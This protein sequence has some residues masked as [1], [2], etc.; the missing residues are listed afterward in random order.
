M[1]YA[2]EIIALSG[3]YVAN[4]MGKYS[5]YETIGI[6]QNAT[7]VVTNDSGPLHIAM[8]VATP[9]ICISNG[10]HFERFCPYPKDMNMPLTVVF[11]DEFEVKMKMDESLNTV[12]CK[13]SEIN[14]N[15]IKPDKVLDT[16]KNS[17]LVNHA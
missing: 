13:G 1:D 14:I 8:A 4:C 9:T 17:N 2:E 6:I 10:N 15:L 16:L 11:P 7:L 12:K 5:L 3:P